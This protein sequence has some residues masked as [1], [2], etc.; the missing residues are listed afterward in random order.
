MLIHLL[1]CNA[2][3]WGRIAI[4]FRHGLQQM[5]L[6]NCAFHTRRVIIPGVVREINAIVDGCAT[7]A[8]DLTFIRITGRTTSDAQ[9]GYIGKPTLW[10][11]AKQFLRK[12]FCIHQPSR[13][14]ILEHSFLFQIQEKNK[15][16][17]RMIKAR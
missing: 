15:M 2:E 10:S 16:G 7:D 11:K 12:N 1:P 5:V 6:L 3:Y 13:A 17:S 14:S 8:D 9:S 4:I